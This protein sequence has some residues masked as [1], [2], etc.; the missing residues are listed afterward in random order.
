MSIQSNFPA[1]APSLLLDFASTKQ[2][3]NRITFTRSTPAV[4]YDGR[5]TAV[6]EQNLWTYSQTFTN[7]IWNN[8]QNATITDNAST[9]PDGTNTAG[10]ITATANLAQI[11]RINLPAGSY[12]Y[13]FS[14]YL[15]RKTGT[16]AVKFRTS[17]GGD[18]TL[19]ITSSW[20]RYTYTEIL[21]AGSSFVGV[22]VDVSGDEVYL[23]GSQIELRETAT[24]YTVTTT[25]AITNYI[26]VLLSA[27]GNQARFDCN[28]TTGESL[29]LLIEEQRTNT[30]IYSSDFT[31]AVWN[32]EVNRTIITANAL[33]APDGTL[34]ADQFAATT[35]NNVHRIYNYNISITGGTSTT[36]SFYAKRNGYDVSLT[37]SGGRYAAIFNLA[38]GV[39][40]AQNLGD[41]ITASMVSVGNG[42]YRCIATITPTPTGN[43][44]LLTMCLSNGTATFTGNGYSG[45]F[46]WGYQ[47]EAG[48]F[49]TSYIAT[50][51]A[52]ATRT[53]D[54]AVMTGTNFSS[55]Y[56][57]GQGT[58]YAEGQINYNPIGGGSNAFYSIDDTSASTNVI[59][60]YFSSSSGILFSFVS[61][62]GSE[63]ANT[64]ATPISASTFFKHAQIYQANNFA[65]VVNNLTVSTDSSG[66]TPVVTQ[67][68]FA[69]AKSKYFRKFAYYPLVVTSSQLQALTS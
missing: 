49:A 8:V 40:T 48:S 2:L 26:P 54:S 10:L 14:F 11:S 38:T 56:N 63:Q 29:G 57:Q 31:N 28:P 67:L 69:N 55:W 68:Q 59:Q 66:V 21:A 20:A 42:W 35:D 61:V 9:A 62:N 58:I 1:I 34:T 4:Y 5:T 44:P 7:A 13:T 64:G 30:Q 24:A 60:P 36:I 65:S 22:K 27:G 23:W 46:I 16:G 17:G 50:T 32:N 51:S 33:V 6:A 3:D 25:Q 12:T 18:I 37:D 39:A 52:S 19:S 45:Y 15:K 53:A 43:F 47:L 41:P